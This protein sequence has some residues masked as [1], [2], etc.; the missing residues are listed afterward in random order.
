MN[1]TSLENCTNIE[2]ILEIL[3]SFIGFFPEGFGTMLRNYIDLSNFDSFSSRQDLF[4]I[5]FENVFLGSMNSYCEHLK[6]E[7]KKLHQM[8]EKLSNVIGFSTSEAISLY[9]IPAMLSDPASDTGHSKDE[10]LLGSMAKSFF[11]SRCKFD[12]KYEDL[13]KCANVW[14]NHVENILNGNQSLGN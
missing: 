4:K 7:E 6:S 5:Q 3:Y 10:L 8:L 11:Y 9:E 14:I 12:L 13:G 2:V 1:C